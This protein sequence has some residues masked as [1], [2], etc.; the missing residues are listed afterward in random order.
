MKKIIT[1]ALIAV[2]GVSSYAQERKER[3]RR[4]EG[5]PMEK[6]TPEQ[7]SQLMLKKM[8]LDLDLN[9]SQ[10][11]EVGKIIAEQSAKR[12]AHL[13]DKKAKTT[14]PTSDEIFEM[15]SKMLDEQIA[16]N[17]KMKKIL[18]PEQFKKWDEIKQHHREGM[19]KNHHEGMKPHDHRGM[20]K[21]MM[22][23]DS[24]NVKK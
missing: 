17:G 13:K 8:T 10:Q 19:R 4:P 6:F 12:E 16:M 24:T 1:I 7:R 3:K 21:G 23:K 9:A 11:K 5:N 14:K 18:S 22:H 2:M 15:K 20:K